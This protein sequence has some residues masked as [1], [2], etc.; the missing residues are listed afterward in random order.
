MKKFLKGYRRL[1]TFLFLFA[2]TLCLQV[3]HVSQVHAN[4]VTD[5]SV[6]LEFIFIAVLVLAGEACLVTWLFRRRGFNH[7]YFAGA[8][9]IVNLITW[10]LFFNAYRRI[11]ENIYLVEGGIV[12][13]E[14]VVIFYLSRLPFVRSMSNK[15]VGILGAAGSSALGNAFSW[16]LG[17]LILF[18]VIHF[19]G[20]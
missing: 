8:L 18:L 5:K 2:M 17:S 11:V 19:K 14:G 3:F 10:V 1:T 6:S 4:L 15:P 16:G 13:L 9:F 20:M 12:I 7:I